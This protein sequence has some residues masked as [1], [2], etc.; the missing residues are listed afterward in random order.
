[1]E[2]STCSLCGAAE[3]V[4][5]LSTMEK[6]SNTIHFKLCDS[7]VHHILSQLKVPASRVPMSEG[8]PQLNQAYHEALEK[9]NE[10]DDK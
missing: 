5:T 6:G 8:L 10:E 2:L 4:L 7:C 1:M 9:L 3:E